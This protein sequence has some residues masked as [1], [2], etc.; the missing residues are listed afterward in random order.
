MVEYHPSI[1]AS[2]ATRPYQIKYL[3][4]FIVFLFCLLY[5]IVLECRIYGFEK[6]PAFLLGVPKIFTRQKYI[7]T[8]GS[9]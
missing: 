1:L 5:R 9:I 2:F 8:A 6:V 7:A 4:C 3:L